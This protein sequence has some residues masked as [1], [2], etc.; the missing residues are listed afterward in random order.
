MKSTIDTKPCYW[1]LV[2]WL[3]TA[4][5][6]RKHGFEHLAEILI[7]ES[8]TYVLPRESEVTLEDETEQRVVA[9]AF[10][11]IKGLNVADTNAIV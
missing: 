3:Q 5:V 2:F 10:I 6:L 7:W 4:T 1:E 9:M 8:G 11:N